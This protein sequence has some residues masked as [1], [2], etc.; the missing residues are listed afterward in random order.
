LV[1]HP[2]AGTFDD[3]GFGMMQEA[4]EH[5]RGNGAVV[6]E[7]RGPL[8]EGLVGGQEAGALESVEAHANNKRLCR[9]KAGQPMSAQGQ[10]PVNAGPALELA[11]VPA[12]DWAGTSTTQHNGFGSAARL[13][14]PADQTPEQNSE[15]HEDP[16]GAKV[17]PV[18][19]GENSAL[20]ATNRGHRTK[21]GT[22]GLQLRPELKGCQS[23]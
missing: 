18:T 22:G 12:E 11:V 23:S 1:L 3:D 10:T 17:V 20:R 13:L 21:L 5:R 2:I 15:R 8:L 7:D 14:A 4:V 6:V 16:S 9:E 19:P